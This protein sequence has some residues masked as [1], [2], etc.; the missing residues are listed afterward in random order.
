[1]NI[2]RGLNKK[3]LSDDIGDCYITLSHS[4]GHTDFPPVCVSIPDAWMG[5]LWLVR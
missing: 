2:Y 4:V 5:S 1:M 3:I